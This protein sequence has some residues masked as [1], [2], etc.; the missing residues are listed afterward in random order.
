[1]CKFRICENKYGYFKLQL[2]YP[3]K[4][5]LFITIKGRWEDTCFSHLARKYKIFENIEDAKAAMERLTI[6]YKKENNEW[7][8]LEVTE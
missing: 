1:M 3:P 6:K 5:I 2:W 7:K 8:P 4:K